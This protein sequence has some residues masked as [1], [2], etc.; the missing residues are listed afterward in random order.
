[1]KILILSSSFVLLMIACSN[2]DSAVVIPANEEVVIE[3]KQSKNEI[4]SID[5]EELILKEDAVKIKKPN[6]PDIEKIF[7]ST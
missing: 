5:S 1:M 7:N 6:K 4:P 2:S 3:T